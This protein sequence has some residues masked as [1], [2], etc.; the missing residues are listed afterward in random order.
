[1]VNKELII[2]RL[3]R[4]ES[5]LQRLKVVAG[6][7][8][9][10]FL[11]NKDLQ[12]IAERNIQVAAQTSIDIGNHILAAKRLSMPEGYKD[13][14]NLLAQAGIIDK[15]LAE[16]M[17]SIAGFRNVLVH[18]YLKVNYEVF[19]ANLQDLGAFKKFAEKVVEII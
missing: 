10:E 16:E 2:E 17:A 6:Y 18:D 5:C 11:A 13:V 15:S 9:E 8:K 7:S 1:M 3:K 4:L 14:F 12:D 19:Y